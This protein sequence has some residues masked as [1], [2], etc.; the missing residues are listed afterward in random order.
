MFKNI[1]KQKF[2]HMASL[3]SSNTHAFRSVDDITGFQDH[4]WLFLEKFSTVLLLAAL[5]LVL[6][7]PRSSTILYDQIYKK[8]GKSIHIITTLR[9]S[10][11]AR[12][13][14]VC[15]EEMISA[16]LCICIPERRSSR[17]IDRKIISQLAKGFEKYTIIFSYSLLFPAS[18]SFFLSLARTRD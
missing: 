2:M 11:G 12:M 13:K 14:E 1:L 7:L 8:K 4:S 9:V 16:I 18:F 6:S 3:G 17:V 10:I 5:R 15:G